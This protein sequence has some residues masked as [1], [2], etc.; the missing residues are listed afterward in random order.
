MS[1]ENPNECYHHDITVNVDKREIDEK[2]ATNISTRNIYDTFAAP[3]GAL[4]SHCLPPLRF[5]CDSTGDTVFNV[6]VVVISLYLSIYSFTVRQTCIDVNNT[7][8]RMHFK[9][10][11]YNP[12]KENKIEYIVISDMPAMMPANQYSLHSRKDFSYFLQL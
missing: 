6:V 3:L 10:N 9:L 2:T 4:Q 12:H 1:M 5:L 7:C 8:M 11:E